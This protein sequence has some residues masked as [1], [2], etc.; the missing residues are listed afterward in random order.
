MMEYEEFRK[1]SRKFL[2]ER[3]TQILWKKHNGE[4][5]D[6]K[7]SNYYRNHLKP[8]IKAIGILKEILEDLK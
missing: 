5:L 8:K 1:K 6:I 3:A 2:T 7:D 4:K